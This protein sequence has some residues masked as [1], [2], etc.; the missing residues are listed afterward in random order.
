MVVLSCRTFLVA[1]S[2]ALPG[3]RRSVL[4]RRQVGG[5][6]RRARPENRDRREKSAHRASERFGHNSSR[7]AHG[8]FHPFP[9]LARGAISRRREDSMPLS[10]SPAS[11]DDIAVIPMSRSTRTTARQA[12]RLPPGGQLHPDDFGIHCRLADPGAEATIG[13]GDDALPA[14]KPRVAADRCA[15]SS[16]CSMKLVFESITPGMTTLSSGSFI[17]SKTF[18]SCAWRGL[19]ASKEMAWAAPGKQCR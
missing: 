10:A 13:A 12:V 15:M 6:R 11:V 5:A 17:C 3:C 4:V 9:W 7:E 16:G 14:D 2:A 18:H 8:R 1:I 19:A